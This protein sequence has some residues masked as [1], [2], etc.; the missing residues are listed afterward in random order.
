MSGQM[1]MNYPSIR[2]TVPKIDNTFENVVYVH[3]VSISAQIGIILW[4]LARAHTCA[5][6]FFISIFGCFYLFY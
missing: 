2:S 6:S 5:Q 3:Y 4:S 1:E